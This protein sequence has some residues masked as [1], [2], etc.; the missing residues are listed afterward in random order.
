MP[1]VFPGGWMLS[2]HRADNLITFPYCLEIW[3]P[4]SPGILRACPGVHRDFF[5]L[6]GKCSTS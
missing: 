6:F 2:M 3:K 4:H 5:T 1:G